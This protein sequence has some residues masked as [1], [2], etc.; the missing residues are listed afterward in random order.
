MC[1]FGMVHPFT[2]LTRLR[3]FSSAR[4]GY[5][6][7][8]VRTSPDWVMT[9]VYPS[10]DSPQ[11]AEGFSSVVDDNNH[12]AKPFDTDHNMNEASPPSLHDRTVQ[13]FETGIQRYN[14]VLE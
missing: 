2:A 7:M 14:A 4:G 13:A 11:F 3:T 9:G 12:V 10:M 5:I 1:S 6:V 8:L